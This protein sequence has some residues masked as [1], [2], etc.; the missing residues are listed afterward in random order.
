MR[1][2]V[3]VIASAIALAGCSLKAPNVPPPNQYANEINTAVEILGTAAFATCSLLPADANQSAQ[4]VLTQPLA[5]VGAGS[6]DAL[7]T[8]L[9]NEPKIWGALGDF[10]TKYWRTAIDT[11]NNL[12]P[13]TAAWVQAENY[14]GA[15]A[16]CQCGLGLGMQIPPQ[17]E[18]IKPPLAL[19]ALRL[20]AA[21]SLA[22][23][24]AEPTCGTGNE[25]ATR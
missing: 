23:S 6:F 7:R 20:R 17:C 1:K 10:Y 12:I 24:K 18:S 3:I 14:A 15:F 19:G 9:E 4:Q 8:L 5:M 2:V 22:S 21:P 11:L 16:I 13:N 25:L